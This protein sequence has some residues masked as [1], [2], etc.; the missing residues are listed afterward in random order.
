MLAETIGIRAA[1]TPSERA[2]ADYI[3]AQLDSFGYESA[4]QP[5]SF[6]TY[7]DLASDVHLTAPGTRTIDANSIQPAPDGDV[8]G[9][10]IDVGQ[11]FV[12][13][14]PSGALGKIALIER[15]E[16]TF[17][18]KVFNAENAGAVGV[19]IFN[20]EPGPFYAQMTEVSGVPVL[21]ILQE[22]GAQLRAEVAGGPVAV[23]LVLETRPVQTKSWNVVAKRAGG[24]CRIVVGGHLDSVPAGPGANDNASGTS[25]VLEIARVLGANG[26]AEGVCFTLFGA[27]EAGLIGSGAYLK[28]LSTDQLGRIEA[29]LNFDMLGVGQ[30]W[31]F[32]GSQDLLDLVAT[33]ATKLGLKYDLAEELPE[34]VGSDHANFA[35]RGIPTLMF[36]CFC[37]ANYHTAADRAESI[38]VE[39]LQQAG[40]LGLGVLAALLKP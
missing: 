28:A 1:G 25:T 12:Q 26:A 13:E 16:I 18:E 11:G 10:L 31:P 27:E 37:D 19:I 9:E 4:L 17:T 22:E 15:G 38:Q 32:V 3:D 29:M 7:V 33:E 36:N 6:E 34:D 8:S 23:R 35:A 24:S 40:E 39:R 30:G 21:A 2:A 5:F 20:N 14:F